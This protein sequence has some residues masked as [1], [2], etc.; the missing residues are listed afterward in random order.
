[1]PPGVP[2]K[3]GA[4]V[5]N[6]YVAPSGAI[7]DYVPTSGMGG[8][9]AYAAPTAGNTQ[10]MDTP[11]GGWSARLREYPGGVP[12]PGRMKDEP[13]YQYRPDG[14]EPPE[15]WWLGAG[16]GRVKQEQHT[17]IETVDGDGWQSF[18]PQ[19]GVK[20]AA[21]DVRRNPPPVNRPTSTMAPRSYWMTRPFDQRFEH[22]LT[23]QHFS[24]ADFRRNYP[25][26]G[27]A[28]KPWRRNTYRMDPAPWDTN[29][30]DYE[31][32]EAPGPGRITSVDITGPTSFS[33]RLT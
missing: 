25:I 10:Y 32:V 31:P 3:S 21:P 30:V 26:L 22:R 29:I 23:G 28:P 11:A 33:H 18:Q 1:M 24:M 2:N 12:D 19:Y 7:G 20:R 15:E 13:L 6:D 17:T 9:P 5:S 4:R 16:P 14:D 8:N 27:M